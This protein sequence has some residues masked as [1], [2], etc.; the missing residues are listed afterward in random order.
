MR[1]FQAS[2]YEGEQTLALAQEPVRLVAKLLVYSDRVSARIVSKIPSEVTV[3][4]KS[5]FCACIWDCAHARNGRSCH[6][7]V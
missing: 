4:A 5:S 7:G 6:S 2:Q 1:S 3:H